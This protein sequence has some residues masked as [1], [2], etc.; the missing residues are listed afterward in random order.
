M[1]KAKTKKIS[2]E[3]IEALAIEGHDV[4]K[5]F[6]NGKMMPPLIKKSSDLNINWGRSMLKDLDLVVSELN[7]KKEDIIKMFVQRELDNH[8]LAKRAR[9]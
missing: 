3:E 2:I 4:N 6:S 7:I 8:F 5:H 9:K 1:K